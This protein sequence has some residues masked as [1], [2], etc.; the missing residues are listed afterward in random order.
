MDQGKTTL[1]LA[2]GNSREEAVKYLLALSQEGRVDPDSK[3]VHGETPLRVAARKGHAG[4]VQQLLAVKGVNPD[5]ADRDHSTPL[6]A[7]A[8]CGHLEV[9]K[10]LLETG[11]VQLN[12]RD[13]KGMTP[14]MW[15]AKFQRTPV[16]ELLLSTGQVQVDFD[17]SELRKLIGK[18]IFGGPRRLDE[19]LV[20]LLEAYKK[21]DV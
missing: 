12:A 7:A 20:K 15:A 11:R 14:L 1:F 17:L 10:L 5:A 19:S 6:I 16:V 3:T 2:A 9:V 18:D 21:F 4:V 13:D 8:L